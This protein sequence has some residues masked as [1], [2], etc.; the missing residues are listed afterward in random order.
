MYLPDA[1]RARRTAK[2]KTKLASIEEKVATT[3]EKVTIAADRLK[4][5]IKSSSFYKKGK[6]T[7]D[8]DHK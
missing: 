1:V 2:L 4:I 7:E 5:D 3:K 8:K 6:N